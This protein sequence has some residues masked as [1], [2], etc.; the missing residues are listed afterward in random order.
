VVGLPLVTTILVALLHVP[1]VT[2]QVKLFAPSGKL[3]KPVLNKLGV[4]IEV[5]LVLLQ[6]PVFGLGLVALKLPVDEQM[7]WSTPGKL[8]VIVSF[9]IC[10]SSESVQPF[11]VIV[12]VN[13]LADPTDSFVT[14]LLNLVGT[15]TTPAP[16]TTVQTP[17]PGVGSFAFK[18]A[19]PVHVTMSEPALASIVLLVMLTIADEVQVPLLNVHVNEFKPAPKLVTPLLN[20][21]GVVICD[22]GFDFVHIPVAPYKLGSFPNNNASLVHTTKSTADAVAVTRLLVTSICTK[23]EH[24]LLVIV[25]WKMLTSVLRPV[26]VLLYKVGV[27]MVPAPDSCVHTPVPTTGAVAFKVTVLAHTSMSVAAA[28]VGRS[29]VIV[30]SAKAEQNAFATVQRKIFAPFSNAVTVVVSAVLLVIVAV[31][32]LGVHK[33]VAL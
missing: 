3:V 20:K 14:E 19:V 1:L 5:A 25:H 16:V 31:V 17:V 29:L 2:V 21:L 7:V 30:T 32:P 24:A 11:L 12:H 27:V 6:T 26:T 9:V 10:T 33:P 28:A 22:A 15:V 8:F 13:K 18:L 23:F 4:V